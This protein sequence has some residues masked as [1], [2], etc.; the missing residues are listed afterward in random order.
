V[1]RLTWALYI[2]PG[3]QVVEQHVILVMGCIEL[4]RRAQWALLRLE[5]EHH[6]CDAKARAE[7]EKEAEAEAFNRQ[8]QVAR[9]QSSGDRIYG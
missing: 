1:A 2:S 6:C 5:W 9:R 4:L 8:L 3:Q 7:A